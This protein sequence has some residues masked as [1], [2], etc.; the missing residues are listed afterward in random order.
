LYDDN[1][2][3]PNEVQMLTYALCFTYARW[4]YPV[5]IPAPVKYA[6]LLAFRAGFYIDTHKEQSR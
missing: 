3:K 1:E 4:I 5:S 6:D 2:L